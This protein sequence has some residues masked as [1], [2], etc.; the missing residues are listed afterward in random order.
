MNEHVEK[1]NSMAEIL[2][3]SVFAL[4][5]SLETLELRVGEIERL[6]HSMGISFESSVREGKEL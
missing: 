4:K 6:L 5:R 1:V 3:S 2:Q